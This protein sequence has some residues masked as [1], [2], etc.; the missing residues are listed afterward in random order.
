LEGPSGIHQK[1]AERA[2][3]KLWWVQQTSSS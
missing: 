3:M 1:M 2:P